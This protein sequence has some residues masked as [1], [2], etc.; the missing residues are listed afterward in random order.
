MSWTNDFEASPSK[1]ECRV[2]KTSS[3]RRRFQGQ[4]EAQ[5]LGRLCWM[6]AMAGIGMKQATGASIIVTSTMETA[7]LRRQVRNR[8]N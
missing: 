5:R 2:L 4:R 8:C 7:R 3:G 1:V 6:Q